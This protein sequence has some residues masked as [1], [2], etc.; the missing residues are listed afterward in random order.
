MRRV[1]QM[2]PVCRQRQQ[3][4]AVD[5]W[6]CGLQVITLHCYSVQLAFIMLYSYTVVGT[7]VRGSVAEGRRRAD[8][9]GFLARTRTCQ[10]GPVLILGG[11]G[12]SKPPG[13][14]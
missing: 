8:V 6:F 4:T 13:T 2:F 9:A 10:R 1:Q 3:F 11:V 12:A 7:A 5:P 14:S